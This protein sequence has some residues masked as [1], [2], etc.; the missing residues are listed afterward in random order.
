MEYPQ[1]FVPTIYYLLDIKTLK[2][3]ATKFQNKFSSDNKFIDLMCLDYVSL[4][5]HCQWSF[6]YLKP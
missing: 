1:H 4:L 6:V 2:N 3:E 5:L